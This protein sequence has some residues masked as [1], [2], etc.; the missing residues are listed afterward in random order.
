MKKFAIFTV[1]LLLFSMFNACE[2]DEKN[3]LLGKWGFVVYTY[4]IYEGT[5][6]VDSGS[7][8]EG[9]FIYL[10]F[11]KGGTGIVTFDEF[12][13]DTFTWEKDGKTVLVDEGT[14]NEQN[15]NIVTLT[16]NTLVFTMTMTMEEGQTTYTVNQ[17]ITMSRVE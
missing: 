16:K 14:Q 12:E 13:S 4:E 11:I 15:I 1:L 7:S 6:L 3:L 10:E 8:T 2:E 5:T 17:T 9:P